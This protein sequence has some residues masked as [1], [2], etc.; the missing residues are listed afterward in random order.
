MGFIIFI[1]LILITL[2]YFYNNIK[3]YHI[4]ENKITRI[5]CKVIDKNIFNVTVSY[6]GSD[7][8][9]IPMI[10]FLIDYYLV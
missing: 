1:V 8:E 3:L 10:Q 4:Y 9:E 7:P 5:Q 2:L 6:V